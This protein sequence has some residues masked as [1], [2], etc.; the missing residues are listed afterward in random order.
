M[1]GSSPAVLSATVLPPVLGPVTTSTRTGGITRTSTGIGARDSGLGARP[2][3]NPHWSQGLK[4]ATLHRRRVRRS[5]PSPEPRTPSSRSP[6]APRCR[7][8]AGMSSGW[9]AA[10]SSSRPSLAIAGCTPSTSSE[11]RAR[12]WS[13]S[14]SVAAST[15]RCRSP[16]RAPER[17]GE[18]EQD[19][20][21]LFGFLLLERDDVVVDLDRAER[22]E[23]QAGA[24]A[25]AAVDDSRNRGAMLAADDEHVAAVAVGDDLLLQIL[26]RV[27]AAQI[28]LERAPQPRALFT[29]PIPQAGQLRARIVDD[30]VRRADLAADVGDLVLEGRDGS[31]RSRRG[32]EKLLVRAARRRTWRPPR[33]GTSRGLRAGGVRARGLRPRARRAA[34][35]DPRAHG[36]RSR[37]RAGS[38]RFP[39][40]PRARCATARASMSGWSFARRVA[41]GG[42]C[43]KRRTASTIRSY[44]SA[45]RAPA[46]MN[47][48]TVTN[49]E[50]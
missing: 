18:R 26:R 19:A 2:W 38:E 7:C 33:R 21:D 37:R 13:T 27:P 29:Q 14:S 10:R 5:I 6:S 8:T 34:R 1:S 45:L 22:L 3:E 41:P 23:E 4:G 32:S 20:P 44:S 25:G 17:I 36:A 16:A 12:A 40:S 47:P 43:A 24:A 31:R 30:L 48:P 39:P 46:C 28:G 11:N 42:V 15:V 50:G 9:R 35:R 49:Y